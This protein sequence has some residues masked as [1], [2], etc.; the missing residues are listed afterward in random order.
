MSLSS[1]IRWKLT[2][3]A[4]P[5]GISVSEYGQLNALNIHAFLVEAHHRDR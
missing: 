5:F 2:K 1:G 3:I 4:R